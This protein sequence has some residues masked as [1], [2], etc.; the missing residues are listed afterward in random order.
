MLGKH[1]HAVTT[2]HALATLSFDLG[3][4]ASGSLIVSRLER[5]GRTSASASKVQSLNCCQYLQWPARTNGHE[6]DAAA[7]AGWINAG[8]TW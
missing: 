5:S 6:G 8:L 2:W 7:V 4:L 1:V 3:E